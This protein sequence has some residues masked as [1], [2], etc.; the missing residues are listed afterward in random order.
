MTEILKA[1]IV[2]DESSARNF[3]TDLL[4]ELPW[5]EV[6]GEAAGVDEAFGLVVRQKP[7]VIFLDVQM[8]G[9]DGFALVEQL[10][11]KQIRVEIIFTTAY[12]RYA[13]RAIKAAA[14]DYLLKPVRRNELAGS[15][16]KLRE[17]LHGS[18]MNSRLSELIF[19][20]SDKKKIKFRIQTGFVMLDAGQILFCSADEA[21]TLLELESGKNTKVS[22]CLKEVEN[23][24]PERCFARISR[25]LVINLHYLTHVD[26]KSM[27]CEI[28]NGTRHLLPVSKKYLQ[29][30]EIKCHRHFFLHG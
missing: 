17:R 29:E 16:E 12:E 27:T 5:V 18:D 11:Q 15:L 23:L 21:G 30:L 6:A 26:R 2:D 9:E 10:L 22:M 25:S 20:L 1:V 24:L 7:D 3:L 19:Q 13:I 4:A 8:S 28:V 14:F